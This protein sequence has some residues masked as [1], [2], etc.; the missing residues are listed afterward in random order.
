MSSGSHNSKDG[1]L[2][3]QGLC[4]RVLVAHNPELEAIL[5]TILPISSPNALLP[6]TDYL[7]V[8]L[9]EQQSR[10]MPDFEVIAN[11]LL[12]FLDG[13][14]QM[15]FIPPVRAVAGRDPVQGQGVERASSL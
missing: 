14:P 7:G 2:H 8:T 4:R 11:I 10:R 15:F 5:I 12:L 3:G 9:D 6:T 1:T 13:Q